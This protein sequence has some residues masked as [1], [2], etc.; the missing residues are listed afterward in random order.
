MT[1][2]V[3]LSL[4]SKHQSIWNLLSEQESRVSLKCKRWKPPGFS[5]ESP[6]GR[7]GQAP[8]LSYLPGYVSPRIQ[9]IPALWIPE[10]RKRKAKD[11]SF[12]YLRLIN[13]IRNFI[14]FTF[15]SKYE[16]L[17]LSESLL[18]RLDLNAGVNLL[19]GN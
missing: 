8:W 3:P 13:M 15:L 7:K 1:A 6:E 10:A 14:T 18:S 19:D 5:V 17:W 12:N 4:G 16:I 9:I 2:M 11:E